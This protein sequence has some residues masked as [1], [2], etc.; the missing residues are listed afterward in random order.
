M[1]RLYIAYG[2]NLNVEQMK[3]RC[4]D[5]R[6]HKTGFLK[7]WDLI[8]RGSMTGFYATIRRKSGAKVP[9]AIWEISPRDEMQL[10]RYEGYPRFYQKENVYVTHEDGS[11]TK[12]M[13]YIMS[14]NALPGKPTM[15]YV[16]T[17]KQG[18]LDIGLD[19]KYLELFLINNKQEMQRGV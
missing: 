16:N 10:D 19:L 12:G 2:S 7:N 11:R 17:I 14:K 3:Q 4:P 6:L 5:A 8:F 13:V 18:Y 9:V 15:N 1:K